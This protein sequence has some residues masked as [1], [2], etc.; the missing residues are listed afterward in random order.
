MKFGEEKKKKKEEK[1]KKTDM[2][3]TKEKH[4]KLDTIDFI[5]IHNHRSPLKKNQRK[6]KIY[7]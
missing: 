7:S 1:Q 2:N 4:I 5:R 6:K 3:K